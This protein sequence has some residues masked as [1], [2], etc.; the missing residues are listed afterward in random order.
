MPD[1]TDGGTTT[2]PVD[3]AAKRHEIETEIKN[4]ID[5]AAN[6]AGLLM[7][8]YG[9]LIALGRVAAKALPDLYEQIAAMIN[10]EAVTPQEITDLA[11]M[12]D[13]LAHPE[14]YFADAAPAAPAPA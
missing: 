3:P 11:S 12:F 10:K 5:E 6:F 2:P 14:R 8:Q 13:D 1:A 7:P 9:P 4:G